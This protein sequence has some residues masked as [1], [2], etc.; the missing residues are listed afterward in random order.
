MFKIE[1]AS[2]NHFKFWAMLFLGC[3][4]AQ[5][6]ACHQGEGVWCT[7]IEGNFFF[8]WLQ[9]VFRFC[10]LVIQGYNKAHLRYL[11]L[12]TYKSSTNFFCLALKSH[13]T[14]YVRMVH[15]SEVQLWDTQKIMNDVHVFHCE[16][17][18]VHQIGTMMSLEYWGIQ[19]IGST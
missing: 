12:M 8:W 5:C 10:W 9:W 1:H 2:N 7:S 15:R 17:N 13:S 11:V 4:L 6:I 3:L 19:S 16:L 14:P 18:Q